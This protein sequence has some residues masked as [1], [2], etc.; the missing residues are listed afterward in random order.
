MSF[1]PLLL[2]WYERHG[3]T[4]PWRDTRDAYRV[5]IS[6]IILQQ[7]QVAQGLDYYRRFVAHFP[8]V[9][10]LAAATEDEVLQM[11]QGLGYYSRARNLHAAAK[12]VVASGGRFP[13]DYAAV[14][15]LPG[16]GPYTAAAICA[17]AY[18]QPFAAVDGNAYRVLTRVF[19]IT[20]PIDSPAGKREIQALADQLLDCRRPADWNAAL[21]DFGATLCTPRQ[22]RCHDCPLADICL[23]HAV[24]AEMS[25]PVKSRRVAVGERYFVYVFV[26]HADHTYLTRRPSGDIWTGLYQPLLL[27]FAHRPTDAETLRLIIETIG[28]KDLDVRVLEKGIKHQLTHRRLYIDAYEVTLAAPFE[29]EGYVPVSARDVDAYAVPKPVE[30]LL[31]RVLD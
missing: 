30:R 8:S 28:L 25:H 4:L 16:I 17:F 2:K 1:T 24:G 18:N 12:A 20:T 26:R 3:R 21:M 13:V 6:E 27:E 5:W 10:D 7:T 29:R 15:A 9:D 14:R 23:A 11:W 19:A 22:P 31:A